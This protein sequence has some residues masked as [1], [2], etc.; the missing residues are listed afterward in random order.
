MWLDG[1]AKLPLGGHPAQLRAKRPAKT[2]V[3]TRFWAR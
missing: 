1:N 3:M 2:L